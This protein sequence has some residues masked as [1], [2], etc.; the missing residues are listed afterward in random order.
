MNIGLILTSILTVTFMMWSPFLDQ[1]HYQLIV[2]GTTMDSCTVKANCIIRG[3]T[4]FKNETRI[5]A[6]A[7]KKVEHYISTH[8]FDHLSREYIMIR[9]TPTTY[10]CLGN[11]YGPES[12]EWK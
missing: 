8:K 2:D 5:K 7:R 1:P 9:L 4:K 10:V 12:E 11:V 6:R 3:R